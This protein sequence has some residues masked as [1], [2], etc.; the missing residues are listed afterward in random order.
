MVSQ[1]HSITHRAPQWKHGNKLWGRQ[2][3]N[4]AADSPCHCSKHLTTPSPPA[5]H[6]RTIVGEISLETSSGYVNMCSFQFR[7][8]PP[9]SPS[10]L[11]PAGSNPEM[12]PNTIDSSLVT[13]IN[14]EDL[15]NSNIDSLDDVSSLPHDIFILTVNFFLPSQHFFLFPTNYFSALSHESYW[16]NIPHTICFTNYS[17]PMALDQFVTLLTH[18][19]TVRVSIDLLSKFVL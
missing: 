13:V 10:S 19:F 15:P 8:D 6:V 7:E 14:R 2:N 1:S 16:P 9:P 5:Y 3:A 4:F 18:L 17:V 12:S 11:L